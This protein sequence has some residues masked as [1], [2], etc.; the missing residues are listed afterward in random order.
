[1]PFRSG[2][3]KMDLDLDGRDEFELKTPAFL[4]G[5]S[6]RLVARLLKLMIALALLI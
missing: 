2:W 5:L 1:L 3:E 6:L 4:S